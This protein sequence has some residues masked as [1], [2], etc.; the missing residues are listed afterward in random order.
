MTRAA[1]LVHVNLDPMPGAFHTS[2]S[3]LLN[4]RGILQNRLGHYNPTVGFAPQGFETETENRASLVVFVDLDP[5][6]GEMNDK[7][8]VQHAIRN[9]LRDQILHY[10]PVVSLAVPQLQPDYL[11]K[12]LTDK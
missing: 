5:V 7:T 1:F 2:E 12:V 10:S 6:P 4:V 8:S 9:I 11:E 3:A